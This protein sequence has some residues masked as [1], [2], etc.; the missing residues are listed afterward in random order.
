M[1]RIG[2]S[3]KYLRR[4][5][6]LLRVKSKELKA[7]DASSP[8][9]PLGKVLMNRTIVNGESGKSHMPIREAVSRGQR[10]TF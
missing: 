8:L 6:R 2:I 7:V 1:G 9:G 5:E 10:N 3:E 4:M